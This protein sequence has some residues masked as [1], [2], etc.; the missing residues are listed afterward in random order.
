MKGKQQAMEGE[1]ATEAVGEE[2]TW[3]EDENQAW[4]EGEWDETGEQ[5]AMGAMFTNQKGPI[6]TTLRSEVRISPF[7]SAFV[8]KRDHAFLERPDLFRLNLA[9]FLSALWRSLRFS[10]SFSLRFTSDGGISG[11]LVTNKTIPFL[12]F[13]NPWYGMWKEERGST[14]WRKILVSKNE[15][16]SPRRWSPGLWRSASA[17]LGIRDGGTWRDGPTTPSSSK[18]AQPGHQPNSSIARS[19]PR[20]QR[21][22]LECVARLY[23]DPLAIG[24][25]AA[26]LSQLRRL[27]EFKIEYP[28]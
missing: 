14:E 1:E 11:H 21:K 8:L 6:R 17:P 27:G 3:Q 18:T 15:K 2:A 23:L 5:G 20:S 24:L 7:S 12:A 26:G 25:R 22:V 9:F 4:P 13:E 19:G 28:Q 10:R 16:R